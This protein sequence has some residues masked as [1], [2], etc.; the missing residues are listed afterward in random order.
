LDHHCCVVGACIGDKNFKSFILS[1]FYAAAYGLANGAMSWFVISDMNFQ[2]N[3]VPSLICGFI[4]A[5]MGISLII[6]GFSFLCDAACQ[7]KKNI[8]EIRAFFQTFGKS[9]WLRLLPIQKETTF[10]A[11]P[12]V[13]WDK[14][15]A[16]A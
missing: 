16:F 15:I 3:E 12:G 6:I 11:W 1:F 2:S 4:S 9:W 5:V 10:L 8:Q 7:K 13:V 14:E